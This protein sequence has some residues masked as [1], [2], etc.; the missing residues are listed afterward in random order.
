MEARAIRASTLRTRSTIPQGDPAHTGDEYFFPASIQAMAVDVMRVR[1]RCYTKEALKTYE[2]KLNNYIN[3]ARKAWMSKGAYNLML[4]LIGREEA[5]KYDKVI[6]TSEIERSGAM[7]PL[8]LQRV[9]GREVK[10]FYAGLD[11]LQGKQLGNCSCLFQKRHR[12]SF[13]ET[14]Y[15]GGP[16]FEDVTDEALMDGPD[17]YDTNCEELFFDYSPLM[18]KMTIYQEGNPP[19]KR[20]YE[21]MRHNPLMKKRTRNVDLYYHRAARPNGRV[22]VSGSTASG[23]GLRATSSS[24]SHMTH[25]SFSSSNNA[26]SSVATSDREEETD[27]RIESEYSSDES[28][29]DDGATDPGAVQEVSSRY[30]ETYDSDDLIS[31]SEVADARPKDFP[32]EV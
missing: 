6:W 26:S 11:C 25:T 19:D 30:R 10:G 23:S 4:N 12:V 3:N 24:R 15:P 29:D 5:R 17:G 31:E 16:G 32:E 8:E 13:G 9:W 22:Y 20:D 27:N 2:K 21:S 18:G 28:S 14:W 7:A 1:Y